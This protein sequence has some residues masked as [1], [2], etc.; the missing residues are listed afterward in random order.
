MLSVPIPTNKEFRLSIKYFPLNINVRPKEFLLTVGDYATL[1][2]VRQKIMDH[3]TE[4]TKQTPFFARVRN[5]NIL[6]LIGKD[7]FVKSI[8]EKGDEVCAIERPPPV[9][10]HD[11][12]FLLEVK[13][14]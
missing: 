8:L 11:E 6:E 9:S 5:K 2:D 14:C 12:V 10:G 4:E 3:I 7:K 1:T 13:I